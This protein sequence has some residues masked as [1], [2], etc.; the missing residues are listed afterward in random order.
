MS[1]YSQII[2]SKDYI[3]FLPKTSLL[4]EFPSVGIDPMIHSGQPHII[5]TRILASEV[6]IAQLEKI[7]LDQLLMEYR[8]MDIKVEKKQLQEAFRFTLESIKR[9]LDEKKTTKKTG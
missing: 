1:D 3:N 9:F 2:S 6:F 8:S 4:D 5:G 7:T